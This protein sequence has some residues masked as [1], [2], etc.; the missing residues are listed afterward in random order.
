[1]YEEI[2]RSPNR[3][4]SATPD[5]NFYFPHES[6]EEA[7]QTAVKA[8]ERAEGPVVILGGAGLGKSLLSDVLAEDVREQ[9]DIVKLHAARLCSRKALL[10]N[11]L[12]ELG[13]PY[14]DLAEGELRMAILDRL[15]PAEGRAPGGLCILV[16]ESHT[17]PTRLLEELRLLTNF[18]RDNEPRARLVLLGSLQLEE[19]F[20]TPAMESFNQ[21]LAARCYLNPMSRD[22]VAGY[23]AHQIRQAGFEPDQ[24]VSQDG[25]M[26]VFD[27]SEGVPR[28]AN[29][30]MD[31]ALLLAVTNKLF[32]V[33]GELIEEAWSSLQQLPMPW[34]APAIAGVD[35]PAAVSSNN[36]VEFGQLEEDEFEAEAAQPA[37]GIPNKDKA[38]SEDHGVDVSN[39]VEFGPLSEDD[40]DVSPSEDGGTSVF[41]EVAE[42]EVAGAEEFSVEAEVS[43]NNFFAAFTEPGYG[44]LPDHVVSSLND[45]APAEELARSESGKPSAE[46]PLQTEVENGDTLIN[47]VAS[48]ESDDE[49]NFDPNQAIQLIE[50]YDLESLASADDGTSS[51]GLQ[52]LEGIE[53]PSEVSPLLTSEAFFAGQ[54]TDEKLIA[55]VEEQSQFEAM[56]YWQNDAPAVP[57]V[58]IVRQSDIDDES[59]NDDFSGND[60]PRSEGEVQIVE[61]APS[62]PQAIVEN[63]RTQVTVSPANLFGDDFDEEFSLEEFAGYPKRETNEMDGVDATADSVSAVNDLPTFDGDLIDLSTEVDES[64][65]ADIDLTGDDLPPFEEVQ[66]E[67]EARPVAEV[68]ETNLLDPSQLDAVA[69][70]ASANWADLA[71]LSN[72]D[73]DPGN[74]LGADNSGNADSQESWTV[75]VNSADLGTEISIHNQVEDLLGQLNFQ[76]TQHGFT[77]EQIETFGGSANSRQIPEDSVRKGPGDEVYAMHRPQLNNQSS[78]LTISDADEYDDDRDLLIVEEDIALP[79]QEAGDKQRVTKQASYSQLFAKLRK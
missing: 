30:I 11:I 60:E 50:N 45:A 32:P 19:T 62:A 79:R 47:S 68:P 64:L 42:F 40:A 12:F 54:P 56:G 22:E 48:W 74:D 28:L 4:F 77:E 20:A 13:L 35:Q 5:V 66:V 65:D 76:G 57:D 27:A 44:E 37:T 23:V 78:E 52:G 71:S 16:D 10:Q 67:L 36:A 17:L 6:I 24:L 31:Q 3:P 34:T 61:D 18:T 49:L 25:L 26:A 38:G 9:F 8:V 53:N 58:R 69:E 63:N 2:F 7:R 15:E 29:Q 43:Q 39:G 14:R 70:S 73:T 33:N 72:F 55:L 51:G 46:E 75:E 59:G 21:R 41:Q 1:M